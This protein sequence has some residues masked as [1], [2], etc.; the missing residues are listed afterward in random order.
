MEIEVYL[1]IFVLKSPT[2]LC[3]KYPELSDT[4]IHAKYTLFNLY[5]YIIIFYIYG[6]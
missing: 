4:H 5:I 1:L 3:K 6:I 2:T